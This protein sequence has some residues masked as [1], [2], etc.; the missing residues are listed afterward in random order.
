VLAGAGGAD[1]HQLGVRGIGGVD[2]DEHDDLAFE[3]LEAADRVTHDRVIGCG[4]DI[5]ERQGER[6]SGV[7][8]GAVPEDLAAQVLAGMPDLAVGE[9]SWLDVNHGR[10]W[11]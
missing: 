8:V 10:Q 1:V 3:T 5:P 2:L 7:V 9:R 4:R 6:L 11:H